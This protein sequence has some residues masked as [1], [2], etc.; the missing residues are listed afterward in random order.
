MKRKASL[1]LV[2]ALTLSVFGISGNKTAV[3]AC[4]NIIADN[5]EYLYTD[6]NEEDPLLDYFLYDL[7]YPVDDFG[8]Y[9]DYN[10]YVDYNNYDDSEYGYDDNYGDYNTGEFNESMEDSQENKE[11]TVAVKNL[12]S[13]LLPEDRMKRIKEIRTFTDGRDNVLAFVEPIDSI[14]KDWRLAYDNQDVSFKNASSAQ[15][16]EI[17]RTFIHEYSHIESLNESQVKYGETKASKGEIK[18]EEGVLKKDSYLARFA[19][20]FWTKDMIAIAENQDPEEMPVLYYQKP[21]FFVSEYA[22][23]NFVEDF[24]ESFAEFVLSDKKQGESVA[25]Q[26]VNFFYDIP[27]LVKLREHMRRGMSS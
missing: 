5:Y 13:K 26:K 18:L 2:L 14:G 23:S 25:S 7:I 21:S 8:F 15:K 24:A 10:N 11:K 3:Y 4:E 1:I 6:Y 22:A 20:K 19:N 12:L 27:E 17:L 9:D 16:K